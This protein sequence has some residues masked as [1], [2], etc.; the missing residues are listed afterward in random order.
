MKRNKYGINF[1][2]GL[3]FESDWEFQKLYVP[4]HQPQIEEFVDWIMTNDK[5]VL[6]GGQIGS[7]KSTFI[8]KTFKDCSS[9][10]PDIS[11]HFDTEGENLS[12]GDFLRILLVGVANFAIG[13]KIDLSFSNLPQELTN[14]QDEKWVTLMDKIS[15]LELSL[16]SYEFRKTLAQKIVEN[17]EYITASINKIIETI[18]ANIDRQLLLF[19]SGIDKYEPLT[20]SYFSIQSSL[21]ILSKYKTIFEV[22]AVHLFDNKWVL[23]NVQKIFLGSFSKESILE[24]LRKRTGVYTKSIGDILNN[25]TDLSGGNPRQALRLLTNYVF[26]KNQRIDADISLRFSMKKTIQDFFSFA[27]E[28]SKELINYVSR[29]NSISATLLTLPADKDTAQRAIYGNWIFLINEKEGNIWNAIVN[30]I[31]T[32]FFK[33]EID[34]EQYEQLLLGKYA[35]NNQISPSGL[36]FQKTND[37]GLLSK[38]KNEL[39]QYAAENYKLNLTDTLDLL[40]ISFFSSDRQD[41]II[42][43]YRDKGIME[44][45]KAYVFSKIVQFD[46]LSIINYKINNT[47]NIVFQLTKILTRNKVGIYSFTFEEDFPDEQISEVDKTRDKMIYNKV[48]WWIPM[49]F[50]PKYLQKWIQLRQIFQIIILEDEIMNVLNLQ[51]VEEDIE[52][53]KKIKGNDNSIIKNLEIVAEYLRIHGGQHNE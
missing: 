43:G 28:P 15:V 33:G 9:T 29:E 41:R 50:L 47:E 22:N 8:N 14:N 1:D 10:Q 42:V 44:A 25:I 18:E 45:V 5:P 34:P 36:T 52:F 26:I 27:N 3:P 21:S 35:E 6:I 2:E 53:Y 13:K 20:A 39:S 7:G 32:F 30:P 11:F 40:S 16:D 49:A 51:Q 17:I 48:I 19:A 4:F 46:D 24:I 38:I 31:V 23:K 37:E 12:E